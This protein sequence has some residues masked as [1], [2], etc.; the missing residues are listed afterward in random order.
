MT[1][2]SLGPAPP[3]AFTST[4]GPP[5]PPLPIA[6]AASSPA[7]RLNSQA[8]GPTTV[9]WAVC[10]CVLGFACHIHCGCGC[11]CGCKRCI[12]PCHA[13]AS[14]RRSRHFCA[15][16][17]PAHAGPGH[18][19]EAAAAERHGMQ[20]GIRDAACCGRS[21]AGLLVLIE[22]AQAEQPGAQPEGVV[23]AWPATGPGPSL[24][25]EAHARCALVSNPQRPPLC[26]GARW[27]G[28]EVHMQ[29]GSPPE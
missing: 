6:A 1:R 25:T 3:A 29:R 14:C 13:P 2:V 4:F 26:F 16:A 10:A 12:H 27:R 18:A 15:P 19:G 24:T 21:Q 9:G 20:A 8:S 5:G 11:G 7:A 28:V 17:Y 22:P 23:L